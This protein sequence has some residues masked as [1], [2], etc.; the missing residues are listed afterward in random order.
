MNWRARNTLAIARVNRNVVLFMIRME[1]K[2]KGS[3]LK[4]YMV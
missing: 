2:G 1:E 4:H 3:E